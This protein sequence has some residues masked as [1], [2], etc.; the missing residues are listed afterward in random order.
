MVEYF[1]PVML[2]RIQFAFTISFHII[3]PAFTIGLAS[4][5][6]V[7]EAL[8]IKTGQNIYME[9]YD[10]W[11]KIFALSFGMGV[12]SGLV[13]SYQFG[14][15]WSEFSYRIGNVVGPLLGF[16]VLTAFFLEATFLGIMLFGR[17]KVSPRMHFTSTCIVAAGTLVSAFW[18]LSVN[19]WMQ[20]PTGY[21]IESNGVLMPENWFQIIFNPSFPY[22]FIH[23]I[24]AAYLSTAFVVAGVSG[25]YFIKRKCI[26]H[27]KIMFI[28]SMLMA[29]VVAPLQIFF[30]DL[31]GLNTLKYQPI[32]VAAMEGAWDTETNAPFR[33]FAV[34]DSSKETNNYSLEIPYLTSMI[35]THSVDGEVKGLKDWPASERPPVSI[36]FYSFRVMIAI[37][38]MMALT[39]FIALYLFL[40]QKLFTAT[41]FHRWCVLLSPSGFIA[42]L[43]GWFVTEVGR[44]PYSV[45]GVLKTSDLVSPVIGAEVLTS[46]LAFIVVYLFVFFMGTYYIINL[47]RKGPG[48]KD[49]MEL[50]GQHGVHEPLRLSE[51][52][53]LEK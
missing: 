47:I 29:L 46:L 45:F 40:K 36:V 3:F 1:D 43:A 41:W 20:T 11:I 53:H 24:T 5:L 17:D 7:L 25:W 44:Q 22:R 19:S 15:N 30:G 38:V 10:L 8:R 37:G 51:I 23:M 33:V 18:I 50:Y 31:H 42:V 49:S 48:N 16:E 28:M 52:L 26:A 21:S 9:I 27:A 12:V 14:T 13:L 35:L 6:V 2:A 34:P 39:G 32:K 4:F